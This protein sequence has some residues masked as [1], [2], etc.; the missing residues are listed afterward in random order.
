MPA[1]IANSLNREWRKTWISSVAYFGPCNS[2]SL[3][4][5]IWSVAEQANTRRSFLVSWG[6]AP[7]PEPN[8]FF[9][10]GVRPCTFSANKCF[11]LYHHLRVPKQKPY[12]PT[13]SFSQVYHCL[14]PSIPC[15]T[16][17]VG[18]VD[19]TEKEPLKD[20][21]ETLPTPTVLKAASSD[22]GALDDHRLHHGVFDGMVVIFYFLELYGTHT[23]CII[24]A[25]D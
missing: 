13:K 3:S 6:L 17:Y 19:A 12:A 23:A 18:H 10:I 2:R 14:R 7:D 20:Q 25:W 11:V 16:G 21:E 8:H 22:L 1:D 4:D 15:Y 5:F 9:S 24:M